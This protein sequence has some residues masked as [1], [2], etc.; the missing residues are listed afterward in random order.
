M[1]LLV[2]TWEAQ[3]KEGPRTCTQSQDIKEE[4]AATVAVGAGGYAFHEHHMKKEAKKKYQEA[5]PKNHHH[6]FHW[7]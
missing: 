6:L 5:H 1:K 3:G 2:A 7:F 4:I